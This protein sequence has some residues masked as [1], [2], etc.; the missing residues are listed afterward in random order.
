MNLHDARILLT[1]A[2]GGIGQALARELASRGA[3]LALVDRNGEALEALATALNDTPGAAFPVA[4]DLLDPA[5]REGAVAAAREELGGLDCLVNLAGLL[6]F[7]PFEEEEEAV[8]ERIV[9]LNTVVPMLLTRAC[10]GAM[11]AQGSGLVVNVGST[12]G[13]IGF[14]YFAT[15]SASKGAMRAF[16]EALRRELADTGVRVAYI[17]PRAVRTPLNTGPVM[18]MAAA[19]KMNMDEPDQVANQIAAAMAKGRDEVYLGF[20]ES[21]FVRINA[22]FPRLVDRALRKQNRTMAPFAREG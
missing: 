11:V 16:S 9:Q 2:A 14:A 3:R 15:Y 4:A 17:A 19:V 20:P 7:R 13:S 18:R 10:L 22:L 6:S 8:I 12:F 21:L 1:G 5:G